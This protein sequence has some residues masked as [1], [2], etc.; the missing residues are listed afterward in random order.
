MAKRK[1]VQYFAPDARML[2]IKRRATMPGGF[3]ET[4]IPRVS[5]DVT[6]DLEGRFETLLQ[7]K[8]QRMVEIAANEDDAAAPAKA[9]ELRWLA[10]DVYAMAPVF[11]CHAAGEMAGLL[12]DT[13]DRLGLDD[14]QARRFC[15]WQVDA[16]AIV[17]RRR[18]RGTV[19]Q[20]VADTIKDTR[21]ALDKLARSRRG[22]D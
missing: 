8:R 12:A 21:H 6:D 18:I 16:L 3:V 13:L 5:E 22:R 4:E 1:A 7:Q 19:P 11:G 14:E 20:D 17:I 9:I 2:D 15:K 10:K